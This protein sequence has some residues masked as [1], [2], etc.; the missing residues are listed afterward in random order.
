MK[1]IIYIEGSPF[2][3]EEEHLGYDTNEPMSHEEGVALLHT[4]K[5]L[6][7]EKGLEFYLGYGTLLGAVRN[8]DIIPGD[9]DLDI[10]IRDEKALLTMLPYLHDNGLRLI[11][12]IAGN[13]YSFRMGEHSYIDIYICRSIPWHSPWSIYCYSIGNK[14]Y[15]P[16]SIWRETQDIEFLGETFLCPQN[17]ARILTLW[18]GK[19]WMTPKSGHCFYYEVKSH[20]FWRYKLKPA[21]QETIAWPY[22]R[23]LILR[24]FKTQADSLAEWKRTQTNAN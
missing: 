3:Y 6:L 14:E 4:V 13:T 19:D 1:K 20:W 24:R 8:H 12:A 16:K 23:H 2:E 10:I 11:R 7:D 22:W 18:Y 9:E 21:I 15:C 5:R 17:P